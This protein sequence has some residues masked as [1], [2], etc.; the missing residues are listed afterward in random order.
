MAD[1]KSSLTAKYKIDDK[2]GFGDESEELFSRIS[3]LERTIADI[4]ST[5]SDCEEIQLL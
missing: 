2:A 3:L 4:A 1:V 5:K